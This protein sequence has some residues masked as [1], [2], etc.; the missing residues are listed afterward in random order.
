MGTIDFG[1]LIAN[2]IREWDGVEVLPHRFGGVE[3]RVGRREIGHVH[4]GGV[5][6]LLVS[7]RMRR[8]LVAAG[9]A[10]AHRTLP[11]SGWISFRLRSEHDVPAAVEL[12]R[13][14][15]DRLTGATVKSPSAPVFP[16]ATLL[17]DRSVDDLPA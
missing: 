7:V 1:A 14:N 15:Y 17:A 9:R 8:D 13:L 5:A 10:M 3:F 11:H 4:V 12:F 6:D 16:N 2:V